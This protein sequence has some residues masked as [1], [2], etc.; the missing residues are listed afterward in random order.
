MK[1]MLKLISIVVTLIFITSVFASCSNKPESDQKQP[2][3]QK[4]VNQSDQQQEDSKDEK[5][6][7]EEDEIVPLTFLTPGD[8][9][10]QALNSDDRIIAEINK[11]LGIK[12]NVQVVP[13]SNWEKINVAVAS[14]DLP[15]VVVNQY[16][17]AAVSQWIR[18]GVLIPI[19]DYFD[20]APTVK[21]KCEEE[22]WSAVDGKFYGYLFITQK[23][24]SNMTLSA[25]GD[26]FEKL[27]LDIPDTLDDFYNVLKAFTT[28]D[29]D[30]NGEDD[31][32]G[33]TSTKPIGNFDF[34]FYAYGL[35]YGDWALDENGNVIPKFEHPA[36][37]QGME[38]LKKLWDEGLIEKEFMLNDR[39]MM[40]E[41]W[42]QGKAGFLTAALYRHVS[43]L[44]GNLQQVNPEG[45]LVFMAPPAG[46]E[47]KRGMATKGKNGMLTGITMACKNPEKAAKF[48]ELLVCPEGRDL[49]TL[50]IEGIH[51]TK[52]GD[53]INY[54]EEERAKDG[55][56][57]N[58]W[59]HP[60]A[61]G[62]VTW[63]LESRYLPQTE[64]QRERAL[65]SVEIAT[66]NQVPNLIPVTTDAEVEYGGVVN[67]IYNQ[68]YMD[69][70]LGKINIDTG[71]AELSKK[72][73]EQGGD[74]ILQAVQ[75]AYEQFK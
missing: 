8:T 14:G 4:V 65:E 44:E 40:E 60:L 56:A 3:D 50:G 52:D 71:L 49:L 31:T 16:P 39:V 58:G 28:Q 64:P 19:N 62:H 34:V 70:L 38:Y 15:D 9:A 2:A 23:D 51:Y 45:K 42:Y 46:P 29:P 17:S 26:W 22:T 6:P 11:R 54:I 33:I 43:R 48:I 20:V 75:Q 36:F 67:E 7:A 63:P 21:A 1:R 61:W 68:Y 32:Y 73:R 74:K 12:L 55:F 30:G 35:P 53:K 24:V 59:A 18:D 47:G 69:M 57:A 37:K 66:K 41:K 72:W 5:Q 25:R 27:G 13:E 10:A